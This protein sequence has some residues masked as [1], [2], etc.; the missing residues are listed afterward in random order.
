MRYGEGIVQ[1]TNRTWRESACGEE[2][3]SRRWYEN[4]LEVTPWGFDFLRPHQLAKNS[5]GYQHS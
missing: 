4:P 1:T 3:E 5:L 2:G